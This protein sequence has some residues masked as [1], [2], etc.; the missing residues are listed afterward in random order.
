MCINLG[1][2]R[3]TGFSLKSNACWQLYTVDLVNG[4]LRY[5]AS[6]YTQKSEIIE[7]SN[8]AWETFFKKCNSINIWNWKKNT[9]IGKSMTATR[10]ILR[11]RQTNFHFLLGA[12]MLT[13]I[14]L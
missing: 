6:G 12:T 3:I 7:P 11:L 4:K 9:I 14:F 2:L 8:E 10:G 13:P 5:D 1:E